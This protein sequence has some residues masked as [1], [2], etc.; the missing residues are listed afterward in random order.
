[1]CVVRREKNMLL[2]GAPKNITDI[3][4]ESCCVHVEEAKATTS[5]M[6]RFV[7]L[8]GTKN[9]KQFYARDIFFF[10]SSSLIKKF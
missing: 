5:M 6:L 3:E 10:Y 1:M 2:C 8:H 4:T 7:L 9:E